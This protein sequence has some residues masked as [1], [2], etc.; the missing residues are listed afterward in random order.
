M[1]L[2]HVIVVTCNVVVYVFCFFRNTD[3]KCLAMILGTKFKLI[4]RFMEVQVKDFVHLN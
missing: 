3:N 2:V 4:K 1:V